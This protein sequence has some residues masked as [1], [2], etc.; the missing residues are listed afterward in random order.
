MGQGTSLPWLKVPSSSSL[1]IFRDGTVNQVA[2]LKDFNIFCPKCSLQSTSIGIPWELAMN[3][4]SQALPRSRD[5]IG[6]LQFLLTHMHMGSLR[7]KAMWGT[8]GHSTNNLTLTLPPLG[9]SWIST[10]SEILLEPLWIK[11]PLIRGMNS[12]A[13]FH[14]N[15]SVVSTI[16]PCNFL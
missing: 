10:H 11:F 5:S 4:V 12:R 16:D 13:S 1:A 2:P 7:G 3:A 15:P 6:A 8:E 9:S 14:V